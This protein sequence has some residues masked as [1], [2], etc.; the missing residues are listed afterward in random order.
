MRFQN[1]E[2]PR[3]PS[4]SVLTGMSDVAEGRAVIR[5]VVFAVARQRYGLA[6]TAVERV[7]PMV[8]VSALPG[9]PGAVL[10]AINVHGEIL[11]V[12]D[13]RQRF[14][15]PTGAY[16]PGARLL[17]ARTPRRRVALPVDEVVGVVEVSEEVVVEPDAVTE[18][19][20]H[21]S[22]IATLADG[23]LLIQDLDSL[24]SVREERQ[25][26][27]SLGKEQV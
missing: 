5:L 8:A 21:V 25:L 24:L 11:A 27:E 1:L 18:G 10:G 14:G 13:L 17:L 6:L 16:G 26:A 2:S 20:V 3:A 22:G 7:L 9:C 19:I 23:V 12:V 4:D 15:L